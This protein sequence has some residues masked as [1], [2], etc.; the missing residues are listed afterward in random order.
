MAIRVAINGFGRIGRLVLRS[1][2]ESGRTDVEVVA[3]ND[4][5]DVNTN[6]HLLKY[7]SVHGVLPTKSKPKATTWSLTA[8]PSRFAPSVT[9]RTCRGQRS[10]LISHLNAPVSSLTKPAQANT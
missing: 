3:I 10:M 9:R 4:L 2:V 6:A 1:I 5:G 8:K 7:D